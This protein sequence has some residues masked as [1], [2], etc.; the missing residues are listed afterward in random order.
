VKHARP[1]SPA[2]SLAFD[3]IDW[4]IERQLEKNG[5]FLED[6]SPDEPSFN[7]GF[8]AEGVAAAWALA[9][10][11]NDAARAQRYERSWRAAVAFITRLVI[12]PQ[13]TFAMG[14]PSGAVGGV[15]CMLSRCDIRIDQVSHCLHALVAGARNLRRA[16]VSGSM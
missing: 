16:G 12:H 5:A 9:L 2:A 7:T 1:D 14:D 11:Q 6:L 8:I 15:R 13:D 3:A 4:A 10:D